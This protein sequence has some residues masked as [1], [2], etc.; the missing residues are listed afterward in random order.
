M[1]KTKENCFK[2]KEGKFVLDVRKKSFTQKVV[3]YWNV[4][5]REVLDAL[6]ALK[7]RLD[8]AIGSLI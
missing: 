2:L 3:R 7:D 5:P 1:D 8:G 6:D 4:L